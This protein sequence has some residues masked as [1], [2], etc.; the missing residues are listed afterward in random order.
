MKQLLSHITQSSIFKNLGFLVSGTVIAQL[1]IVVSQLF[2]RRVFTPEDFGA[3]AVY[4]SVVGIAVTVGSLRF[5]QAILLPESHIEGWQLS[6]IAIAISAIFSFAFGAFIFFFQEPFANLIGLSKNYLVWLFFLPATI[7]VFNV[8]LALNYYLMRQNKFRVSGENKIIRRGSESVFQIVLGILN[9]NIGLIIGDIVGQLL[10]IFRSVIY[11]R[12]HRLVF[13]KYSGSSKQ[14]VMRYKS[15][16][17]T[18][19]IPSL[20]NA[21]SRLLPVIIISRFFSAE[22]TGFFDLSR[23]VLAIPLSLVTVS[24]NQ[25]LVKQFAEKRNKKQSVKNEALGVFLLL[26]TLAILFAFIIKLWGGE[27]F[28]F[29]FG[30]GWK[31]SG[32]FAEILVWAFAIKFII[33]P[34]NACFT[35]FEKIEIGSV[36]QTIYFVMIMSLLFV[37]MPDIYSF[38]QLYVSIE[39]IAFILAAFINFRILHQYE[40]AL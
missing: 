20:L 11:L 32:V 9:K 2:L 38:L 40:K 23:V 30:E 29:V 8:A 24:L 22:V 12:K 28:A 18:N 26:T 31:N 33:S 21:F 34:F 13:S 37:S 14:L 1:I 10:L 4:M 6:R 17:L 35:A 36:W 25:V 15:F 16:P 5:E 7:F 3:F 27:L 39:V 19:S